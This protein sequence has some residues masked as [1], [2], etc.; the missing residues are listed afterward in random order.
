L[1]TD[2]ETALMITKKLHITFLVLLVVAGCRSSN[3]PSQPIRSNAVPA[4]PQAT[5][6]LLPTY[7]LTVTPSATLSGPLTVDSLQCQLSPLIVPT[8]PAVIPGYTKLDSSTNLHITGTYQQI[9]LASYQ[10]KVTGMVDYPLSLTMDEIRCLPR[11]ESAAP[12]ICPGVFQ[13]HANWAGTPIHN[14]LDLAGIQ[15]EATA[16]YF[17]GADGYTSSVSLSEAYSEDNFLAYEWNNQPLPIL[18]GFPLRVV[19][20][21]LSGGKWVKWVVEI[22]VQ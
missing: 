9:N 20:P 17:V 12:L 7:A 4:F 6:T 21:A 5:Q 2:E 18:H 11:V 1:L 19:F 14:V 3:Q 10:L 13:D 8:L 15:S 22:N 16:V